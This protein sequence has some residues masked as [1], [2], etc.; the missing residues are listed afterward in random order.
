MLA[1]VLR[2]STNH[3]ASIRTRRFDKQSNTALTAFDRAT[4][5]FKTSCGHPTRQ[6]F[7]RRMN[8]YSTYDKYYSP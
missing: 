1:I 2:N 7:P 5:H 3:F 6:G 4:R 8:L